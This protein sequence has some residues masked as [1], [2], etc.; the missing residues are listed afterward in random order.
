MHLALVIWRD[1]AGTGEKWSQ[2][3]DMDNH[4][5]EI[6]SVGW[7]LFDDAEAITLVPHL[8][9]SRTSSKAYRGDG[10]TTIPRSAV[11]S[12]TMIELEGS[13]VEAG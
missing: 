7:V 4:A 3:R 11:Q 12:V 13:D 2:L 5:P 6:R 1:S 10:G 8:T 9:I